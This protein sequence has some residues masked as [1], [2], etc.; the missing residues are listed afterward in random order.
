MYDKYRILTSSEIQENYLL[1]SSRRE[2][3]E[4]KKE[5]LLIKGTQKYK[6]YTLTRLMYTE[7]R[8]MYTVVHKVK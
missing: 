6:M 2:Y 4:L 8:L 3:V 5:Y 7:T 1:G